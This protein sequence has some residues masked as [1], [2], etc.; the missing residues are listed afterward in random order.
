MAYYALHAYDADVRIPMFTGLR[1]SDEMAVDLRFAMQ[2]ENVETPRGVL[3]PQAGNTIMEGGFENRIETIARFYRRWYT[4]SGSKEWLVCACGGKLYYRQSGGRHEWTEIQMPSG[5]ESFQSNTWSWVTYEDDGIDVLLMSNAKD[6][7]VMVSPPDRPT[8]WDDVATHYT[9]EELVA[10]TWDE[11][12]SPKWT[13]TAVDTGDYKFGVIERHAERIWGGAIP[14]EPDTLVYSATYDPTDWRQYPPEG[15]DPDDP[16]Y[17]PENGAGDIRQPSWDGDSFTALRSFGSQ[18]IAFKGLRVWR[19][20][21]VSPGEYQFVE[22]YGGGTYFPNTI[23]VDVQRILL[24]EKDGLSV[25]DGSTVSPFNR[26]YIERFWKT[27]NRDAMH[28]M[29]AALFKHRYYIAVPTGNS[30]VNNALIVYNTEEGSFLVYTDIYIESLLATED[31]LYATTSSLPGKVMLINYDSWETGETSGKDAKWETPWMDFNF[32]TIAKGGYEIYFNPEVRTFP[33][34]F[35]FSI[36]TEKKIKTK[37]VTIQPTVD[38][39]KQKRIRFGG[40]SRR[41]KLIIE[42]LPV[43]PKATWRLTGGVQMV[44]ETDPD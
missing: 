22:Q 13:I 24:A 17:D 31:I 34:T 14:D 3:Q 33:V 28:Q 18:L 42:A 30:T 2:A 43:S 21:G 11:V 41:F 44:V 26:P 32:K 5:V 37:T 1:Q 19:I 6:G 35:R 16:R 12:Y 36:Q 29:C 23:C 8:T 7:M 20:M 9:W 40:T 4:G 25:Y 15:E 38:K 39:N 27:I 10:L